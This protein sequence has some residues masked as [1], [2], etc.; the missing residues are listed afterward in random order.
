MYISTAVSVN[1]VV[2]YRSLSLGID[3]GER[4]VMTRNSK[5]VVAVVL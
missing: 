2:L 4:R 3:P 1:I 5:A